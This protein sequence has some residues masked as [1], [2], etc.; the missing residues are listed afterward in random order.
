M[1]KT[2]WNEPRSVVVGEHGCYF[3][4]PE[5]YPPMLRDHTL[6]ACCGTLIQI[7]MRDPMNEGMHVCESCDVLLRSE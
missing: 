6:C 4:A 7:P 1:A 3:C 2:V 5:L